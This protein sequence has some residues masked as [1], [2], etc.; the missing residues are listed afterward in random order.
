MSFISSP[1]TWGVVAL[2]AAASFIFFE[3]LCKLVSPT[4]LKGLAVFP[5]SSPLTGDLPKLASWIKNKR[6]L[7]SFFDHAAEKLGDI[8][9]IRVGLRASSG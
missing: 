9:Q 2:L 3:T 6:Q 1:I 8:C 4:G 7:S 5:D